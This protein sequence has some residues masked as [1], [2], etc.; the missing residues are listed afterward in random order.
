MALGW[1]CPETFGESNR[2]TEGYLQLLPQF[3]LLRVA[4]RLDFRRS[5]EFG[6][7]PREETAGR[8]S[9]RLCL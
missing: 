4:R 6:Y 5:L 2:F 8:V 3:E 1:K 7:P 9:D